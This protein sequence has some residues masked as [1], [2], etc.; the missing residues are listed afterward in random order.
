VSVTSLALV[1]DAGLE[2]FDQESIAFVP[3]AYGKSLVVLHVGGH[4]LRLLTLQQEQL[5]SCLIRDA[6]RVLE[7]I[8]HM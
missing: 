3:V 2:A 1:L 7:V 5:L 4:L 8:Q 6:R